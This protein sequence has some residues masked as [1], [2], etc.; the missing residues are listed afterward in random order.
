MALNI[1][2]PEI[3]RL[4]TEAAELARESRT[5]AIRKALEDRVARLRMH[6]RRR[7]RNDRI[8]EVL[9]RFRVQFPNGEF[10]RPIRKKEKED[11]LGFDAHGF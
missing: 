7:D 5:E 9:A 8:D 4:A 2:N 1:R 10:G 3:E 6:R 11:L